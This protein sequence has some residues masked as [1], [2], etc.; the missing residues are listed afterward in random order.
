MECCWK[1]KQ[2]S[3]NPGESGIE[4][5]CMEE[6]EWHFKPGIVVVTCTMNYV[7][8]TLHYLQYCSFSPRGAAST[9]LLID[10][11]ESKE[12]TA[13]MIVK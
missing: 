9:R 8:E 13:I 5:R 12:N 7:G 2:L 6:R 10:S 3:S 1:K 11:I 4:R